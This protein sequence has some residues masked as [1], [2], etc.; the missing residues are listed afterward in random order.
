MRL[1]LDVVLNQQF[2]IASS[3]NND[4]NLPEAPHLIFNIGNSSLL[5]V[6]F[7]NIL[8]DNLGKKA[9]LE[10]KPLQKEM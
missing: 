10:F 5:N 1:F 9:I 4:F 6:N 3:N 8:E 7:I 2:E